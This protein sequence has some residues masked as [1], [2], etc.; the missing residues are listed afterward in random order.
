MTTDDFRLGVTLA[1]PSQLTEEGDL[2]VFVD[3]P[4]KANAVGFRMVLAAEE[5][6]TI[7]GT[8]GHLDISWDHQVQVPLGT[9]EVTITLQSEAEESGFSVSAHT[10]DE[11]LGKE[12]Y[13]SHPSE[14]PFDA[15]GFELHGVG[16]VVKIQ[17]LV[18]ETCEPF[19]PLCNKGEC[20]GQCSFGYCNPLLGCGCPLD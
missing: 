16:T 14:G 15:V 11:F 12:T 18:L 19:G 8:W 2:H 6:V 10:P 5:Q 20:A 17:H 1:V 3:A 9:P 13:P 7:M 4:P